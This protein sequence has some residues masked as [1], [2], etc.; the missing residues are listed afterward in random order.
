MAE[1]A[2]ADG[3]RIYVN[4]NLRLDCIEAVGFDMDYTL[5]RYARVRLEELAFRLTLEKLV[6]R[7]YPAS[8]LA[9]RYEPAFVIR[10][11]TVDKLLGNV[12]KLDR[13][14]HL[15]RAFH[16][17]LPL[18]KARRRATYRRE[19]IAFRPPRFAVVDTLFNLPEVD[20]YAHLV[21]HL[22][23]HLGGHLDG[24]HGAASAQ[25]GA[26]PGGPSNTGPNY[27]QMF[28]DVR[29]AIDEAHRDGS[30]KGVVQAAL[31]DYIER[32]PHLVP[33]LRGLRAAGKKVFLLTNSGWGYTH[34]VMQY[35][36]ED[37]LGPEVGATP[38]WCALFDLVVVQARKPDFFAHAQPLQSLASADGLASASADTARAA[39]VDAAAATTGGDAPPTGARPPPP[40]PAHA[41]FGGS[42]TAVEER[43]QVRG[44]AV[45][46]V[47]DHIYGDILRSKKTSLWRTALVVEELEDEVVRAR[48][49]RSDANALRAL[50]ARRL[51]LETALTLQR[52]ALSAEGRQ[53]LPSVAQNQAHHRQQLD[54]VHAQMQ[55]LEDEVA[56]AHNPYW[57]SVFKEDH[58]NSRFGE[59]VASYACI[60]MARAT[61]L[62]AY[63][64]DHYFRSPR[65]YMP[66]EPRD[67]ATPEPPPAPD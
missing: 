35:L 55:A 38:G 20:V 41:H 65:D 37:V 10:G 43:L 64:P 39:K 60:Y 24:Q 13:H 11:L 33:M 61:D 23:G 42:L 36:T 9:L 31:D 22:D 58:E 66:H 32:D 2:G 26:G 44:E 50:E 30:L 67:A 8:L 17:R 28:D 63:P 47:G 56:S 53:L 21:N 51:Q 49:L 48:R 27:A 6:A 7:G 46:Y 45:L 16:G 40:A 12:L 62:H 19:H 5:A 25:A 15:G 59:Q 18:D 34:A 29:Q 1:P 4:R 54:E 57:G 14:N 3:R 52:N